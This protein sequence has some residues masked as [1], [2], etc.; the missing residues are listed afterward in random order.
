MIK[1]PAISTVRA[2]LDRNSLVKRRL[3]VL[4]A[5]SAAK[6]AGLPTDHGK[7]IGLLALAGVE[8]TIY[9]ALGGV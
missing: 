4:W 7:P 6:G 1:P 8:M 3:A 2:V 9:A 5:T